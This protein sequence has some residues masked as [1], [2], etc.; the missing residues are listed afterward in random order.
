MWTLYLTTQ[1]IAVMI[2]DVFQVIVLIRRSLLK[3]VSF[4]CMGY[5]TA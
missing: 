4:G 1:A 3:E 2:T 5:L